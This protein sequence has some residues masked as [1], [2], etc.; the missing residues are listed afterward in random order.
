MDP[1]ALA[2]GF[3][4]GAF[5]GASGQYLAAKYTD[6]RREEG[7]RIHAAGPMERSQKAIPGDH[8]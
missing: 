3:L 7:G 5:T 8:C 6:K 2:I 1:L 4:V